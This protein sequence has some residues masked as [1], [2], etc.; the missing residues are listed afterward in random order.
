M[1]APEEVPYEDPEPDHAPDQD[2]G[3]EVPD[4]DGEEQ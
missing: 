3:E 2:D 1:S 4:D